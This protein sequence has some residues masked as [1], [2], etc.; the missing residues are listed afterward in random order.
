MTLIKATD[1]IPRGYRAYDLAAASA[2]ISRRDADERTATLASPQEASQL[3][4]QARRNRDNILIHSITS[5]ATDAGW[6][7]TD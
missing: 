2:A 1:T 7:L 5:K 6:N 4:R 3:L